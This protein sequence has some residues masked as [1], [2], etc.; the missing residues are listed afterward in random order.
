MRRDQSPVARHLGH[1]RHGLGRA[2]GHVP[3]GAVFQLA[4]ARGSQLLVGNLAIQQIPELV[5]V[6]IAG[7]AQLLRAFALPFRWRLATLGII[8]AS[9]LIVAG[10]LTR[11]GQ[12]GHGCN[13]QTGPLLVGDGVGGGTAFG[14]VASGCF[15]WVALTSPGT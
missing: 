10:G 13:H 14:A 5:A 3:A 15:Q 7:Q 1:D 11:T 8:F 4:V 9:G 2:Q 6:N 12:R